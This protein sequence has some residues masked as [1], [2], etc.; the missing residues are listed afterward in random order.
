MG[1]GRAKAGAHGQATA[2]KAD[3]ALPQLYNSGNHFPTCPLPVGSLWIAAI[4]VISLGVSWV[5]RQSALASG[6]FAAWHIWIEI[7]HL[8]LDHLSLVGASQ[9]IPKSSDCLLWLCVSPSSGHVPAPSAFRWL[10]SS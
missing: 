9:R 10:R 1:S 8:T 2:L 4:P 3:T 6:T 5:I 7:A